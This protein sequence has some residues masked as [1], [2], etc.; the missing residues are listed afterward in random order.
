VLEHL[1]KERRVVLVLDALD[2]VHDDHALIRF[3]KMLLEPTSDRSL[4]RSLRVIVTSR[5]YKVGEHQESVFKDVR[6]QYARLELFD[7]AQQDEYRNQLSARQQGDLRVRQF[8]NQ[9]VPDRKAV[10]DL[11]RYPVVLR[12]IREIIEEALHSGEPV[13]PFRNRGDLYWEVE[14]RLLQRAFKARDLAPED[15][16]LLFEVMVARVSIEWV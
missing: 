16:P 15:R 8:W 5:P 4:W 9:I 2:Q 10:A 6:W 7:E 3:L 1:L 13:R 14:Q 12:M 11:L